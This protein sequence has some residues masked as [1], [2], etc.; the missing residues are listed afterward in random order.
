MEIN[1]INY[2]VIGFCM[3]GGFLCTHR[4]GCG[5]SSIRKISLWKLQWNLWFPDLSFIQIYGSF[6]KLRKDLSHFKFWFCNIKG[7]VHLKI[8]DLFKVL[9]Q[10]ILP[11]FK[12]WFCE[13]KVRGPLF[14]VEYNDPH[15]YHSKL[16]GFPF[17]SSTNTV[18]H[19]WESKFW[20]P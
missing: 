7:V 12:I 18:G 3:V 14:K 2:I 6:Y 19:L 8:I 15:K 5:L 1:V 17:T 20:L 13:I 9:V 11:R 4:A 10:L 16:R